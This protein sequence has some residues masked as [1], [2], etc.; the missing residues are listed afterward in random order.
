MNWTNPASRIWPFRNKCGV[1]RWWL[2][3]I[4]TLCTL[5][6]AAG[7]LAQST[8]TPR[9]KTSSWRNFFDWKTFSRASL[10]T[11]RLTKHLETKSE[12]WKKCVR[13]GSLSSFPCE[14]FLRMETHRKLIETIIADHF[15]GCGFQQGRGLR[16][17][18]LSHACPIPQS[19]VKR[20]TF[21]CRG[22]WSK[23]P[24]VRFA[25][26]WDNLL[27]ST[28]K[29]L[30]L[31]FWGDIRLPVRGVFAWTDA[32]GWTTK[33]GDLV[34]PRVGWAQ[35][36]GESG[37]GWEEE[38]GWRERSGGRRGRRIERRSRSKG[39]FWVISCCGVAEVDKRLKQSWWC[40]GAHWEGKNS[41]GVR[42]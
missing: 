9:R 12:T 34:C 13:K 39:S 35:V 8:I 4:E 40:Q 3:F 41:I 1:S 21:T 6:A 2:P 25:Q 28:V 23:D 15:L 20:W 22:L 32:N 19:F 42:C 24:K 31:Q 33:A 14:F 30:F 29:L 26:L 38:R 5:R 37:A 17:R 7:Q 36:G 27:F 16:Q 18:L 10:L 11:E